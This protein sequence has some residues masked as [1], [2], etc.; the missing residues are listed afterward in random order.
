MKKYIIKVLWEESTY[1]YKAG[2][3]DLF[4]TKHSTVDYLCRLHPEL[5]VRDITHFWRRYT[6]WISYSMGGGELPVVDYIE[7]HWND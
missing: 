3:D 5:Q 6:E 7:E 2:L 4:D 1:Y